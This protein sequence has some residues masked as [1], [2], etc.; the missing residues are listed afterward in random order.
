MLRHVRCSNCGKWQ[1]MPDL[2][3]SKT[4][5]FRKHHDSC[6][7]K[8]YDKKKANSK[9][10]RTSTLTSAAFAHIFSRTFLT[11]KNQHPCLLEPCPGLS[12]ADNV[13]I[14]QY[15]KRS[16]APGGGARSVTRIASEFFTKP[17]SELSD[18]KQE[19]VN[20]Q[21]R[22]EHQ[23]R[24][25]HQTL[26]VFSVRCTATRLGHDQKT[27]RILPCR[28]CTELLNL[29]SFLTIINIPTPSNK[30]YKYINKQFR[31]PI[32]GEQYAKIIGLKE[33]LDAA[34]SGYLYPQTSVAML[35]RNRLGGCG[36][37]SH[38]SLMSHRQ[39]WM[40]KTN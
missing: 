38:A 26:R 29:R 20:V 27:G 16:C 33:L 15:L 39:L 24:N 14:P 7:E 30:N 2:T 8:N 28:P 23:W 3:P 9:T 1:A 34:G 35:M 22:H 31:N 19:K 10:A 17:F 12:K 6:K 18:D 25:N 5:V 37:I 21:Q 11:A 4:A 40:R 32:I 13:R 36:R